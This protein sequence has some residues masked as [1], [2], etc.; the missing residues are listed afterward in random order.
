VTKTTDADQ[1]YMK[2]TVATHFN[3][4]DAFCDIFTNT[5]YSCKDNL[6]KSR[7]AVAYLL[8]YANAVFPN[9][10]IVPVP[11]E[12]IP[13]AVIGTATSFQSFRL[14]ITAVISGIIS[15]TF[16]LFKLSAD[17]WI[18]MI[19]PVSLMSNTLYAIQQF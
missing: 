12:P 13:P 9:P 1:S 5:V 3:M 2:F 19:V 16:V 18:N 6:G 7:T 4:C 10:C 14:I 8:L 17:K 11:R 15:K